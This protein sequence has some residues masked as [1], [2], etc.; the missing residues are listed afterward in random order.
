MTTFIASV[1]YGGCWLRFGVVPVVGL[2]LC[3]R[4]LVCCWLCVCAA[5][6]FDFLPLIFRVYDVVV[7]GFGV[8]NRC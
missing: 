2:S 5:V 6:V 7:V 8:G 3:G 4:C 1:D